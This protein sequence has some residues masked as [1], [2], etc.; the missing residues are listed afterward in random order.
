MIGS[1]VSKRTKP[2]NGMAIIPTITPATK[3]VKL[4]TIGERYTLRGRGRK[5]YPFEQLTERGMSFG[6]KGRT[7]RQIRSVVSARN[8][9]NMRTTPKGQEPQL[10]YVAAV[11]PKKD[12]DGASVR[13]FRDQ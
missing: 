5:F 13:V 10:F 1:P 7:I 2:S 3:L 4:P 6:V 11:D 8:R 9:K 12:V